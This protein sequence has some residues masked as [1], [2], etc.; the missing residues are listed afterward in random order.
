M[1]TTEMTTNI[2]ATAHKMLCEASASAHDRWDTAYV[3]AMASIGVYPQAEFILITPKVQLTGEVAQV[4]SEAVSMVLD[5]AD[6][7]EGHIDVMS[8][9]RVVFTVL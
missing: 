7:P 5:N 1:N 3:M 8:D 2:Y 4:F 6:L 9:Y